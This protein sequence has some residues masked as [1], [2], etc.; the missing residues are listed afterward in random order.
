MIDPLCL[1]YSLC[2]HTG[3]PGLGL[4]HLQ[5]ECH[6][7]DIIHAWMFFVL[8]FSCLPASD[9]F[10]SDVGKAV[11]NLNPP[12]LYCLVDRAGE[13]A[14]KQVGNI[15]CCWNFEEYLGG[16][17]GDWGIVCKLLQEAISYKIREQP[18]NEPVKL[19]STDSGHWCSRYQWGFCSLADSS[20]RVSRV[21]FP[22]LLLMMLG[23]KLQTSSPQN[24]CSSSNKQCKP[25]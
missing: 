20:P 12:Q 24:F 19:P 10:R 11:E 23:I 15:V 18:C 5:T 14:D 2:A 22:A 7:V 6:L 17:N 8:F 4:I 9:S 21:T 1:A 3:P 16:K 25:S 13:K